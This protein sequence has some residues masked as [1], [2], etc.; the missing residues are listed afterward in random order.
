MEYINSNNLGMMATGSIIHPNARCHISTRFPQMPEA[1][2]PDCRAK[3]TENPSP[4]IRPK[5]KADDLRNTTLKP[6]WFSTDGSGNVFLSVIW[7]VVRATNIG[8]SYNEKIKTQAI[9]C[10]KASQLYFWPTLSLDQKYLV[11]KLSV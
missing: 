8:R 5:I 9:E 11:T 3:A 4:V 1:F 10:C 6:R 7:V 2:S